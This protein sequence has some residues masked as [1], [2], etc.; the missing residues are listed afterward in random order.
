MNPVLSDPVTD[1]FGPVDRNSSGKCVPINRSILFLLP[2]SNY[3]IILLAPIVN[4]IY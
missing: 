1:P 3:L 4:V 2:V